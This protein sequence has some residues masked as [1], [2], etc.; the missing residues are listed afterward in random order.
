MNT[1]CIKIT[2]RDIRNMK[3]EKKHLPVFGIGPF[4][5]ISTSLVTILAMVLNYTVPAIRKGQLR[6]S[7]VVLTFYVFGCLFAI[8]GI[9]FILRAMFG[10]NRIYDYIM[11]NRLCTT[12]VYAVVRNP[13]FSGVNHIC[14][15]I[16]VFMHNWYLFPLGFLSWIYLTVMVKNTEEK[17]LTELHGDEYRNYC[18]NVNR[19]I[20]RLPRY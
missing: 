11:T 10:H 5:I 8:E 4:Y 17:W 3:E 18:R 16:L 19:V 15:G 1:G 20:P 6:N 7:T 12:G 2:N 9:Y 14:G 13:I